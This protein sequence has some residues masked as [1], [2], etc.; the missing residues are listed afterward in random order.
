MSPWAFPPP[1]LPFSRRDARLSLTE[2]KSRDSLCR[3]LQVNQAVDLLPEIL[4]ELPKMVHVL[5][6]LLRLPQDLL[7]RFRPEHLVTPRYQIPAIQY[8]HHGLPPSA[9][10]AFGVLVP[11]RVR[12]PSCMVPRPPASPLP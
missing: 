5:R 4:G 9:K 6:M 3:L 2:I 7:F 8:P 1:C 12:M 10:R 11:L